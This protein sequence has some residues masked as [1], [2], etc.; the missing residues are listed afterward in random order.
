MIY[1]KPKRPEKIFDRWI[2]KNLF[3]YG[4]TIILCETLDELGITIEE[5]KEDLERNL[6][7][8]EDQYITFKESIMDDTFPSLKKHYVVEVKR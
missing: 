3:K 6:F 5:A 2:Y 8:K 7:L 4:N 1:L